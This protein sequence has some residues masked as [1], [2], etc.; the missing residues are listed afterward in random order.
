M[1]TVETWMI[2]RPTYGECRSRKDEMIRIRGIFHK[3]QKGK[4]DGQE[5]KD[6]EMHQAEL[7]ESDLTSRW[8]TYWR[9]RFIAYGRNHF[10]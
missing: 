5:R 9:G 7:Q 1:M 4:L 10:R 3:R 6:L 2:V 8:K